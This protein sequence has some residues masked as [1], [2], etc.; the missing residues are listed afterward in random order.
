MEEMKLYDEMKKSKKFKDKIKQKFWLLQTSA[1]RL[2]ISTD[3]TIP[4]P[5]VR[6][7]PLHLLMQ[8]YMA[9]PAYFIRMW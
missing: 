3:I 5:L 6:Q 8:A 1:L 4:P 9:H 2:W 7:P